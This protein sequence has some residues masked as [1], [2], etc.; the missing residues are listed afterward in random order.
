MC[1]YTE[2]QK[3][4]QWLSRAGNQWESIDYKGERI[5]GGGENA[6]YLVGECLYDCTFF[7]AHRTVYLKGVSFTICKLYFNKSV[8]KKTKSYNSTKYVIF[9]SIL[10]LEETEVQKGQWTCLWS[11]IWYVA[12]RGFE[13]KSA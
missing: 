5:F 8:F 2:Q 11:H 3:T 1:V 9:L 12:V 4:D 13:P 10:G 6:L 7:M